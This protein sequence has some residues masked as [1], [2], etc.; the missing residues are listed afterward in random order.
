MRRYK[1]MILI[2]S[3]LFS[4]AA[5]QSTQAS[6]VKKG[7][8]GFRFLETPVS[9]EA[10][11]RGGLGIT[12]FRNSNAVFWNPAGS[13][14]MDGTV[15]F[16]LNYTSG[17]ADINHST[18]VGAVHFRRFVFGVSFISMDYGTLQGTRRA[19]NDQG[20]IDT[21]TFSP[22]ANALGFTIS[23]RVSDRFSYGVNLKSAFQDLGDAAIATAGTDV[24]DPAFEFK[25]KNY[26]KRVTAFDVGAIYDFQVYGLRFG[27]VMQNVSKEIKYEEEKFP[28]PYSMGF[29]LAVAPLTFLN[30]ALDPN[31]LT[32]GI[33]TRHPRD[34]RERVKFGAEYSIQK[35]AI[36]RVGYMDNY[37]QRGLTFGLGLRQEYFNSQL[38]VDYAYQDFGIFNAVHVVTF[39]VTR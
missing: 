1:V 11:G 25:E 34:F 8:V 36:F 2:I 3:G 38:R 7:Q 17:I 35:L 39:G 27:A 24:D 28:L 19:N 6:I 5:L 14:W 22:Q 31:T 32:I 18:V 20:F 10:I 33:E 37:D 29:S 4:L 26:A 15:D 13:A 23:Q 21:G 30:T 9:A 16:N 12:L